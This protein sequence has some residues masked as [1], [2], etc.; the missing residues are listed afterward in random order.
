ML[1]EM[2]AVVRRFENCEY[3]P[4]D[5]H[6][7]DH[8][9]VITWYLERMPVRLALAHM[10]EKLAK[11]SAHHNRKGYNETITCFWIARVAEVLATSAA[12]LP[13]LETTNHVRERLGNKDLIFDY[14]SRECLLSEQAKTTWLDPDLQNL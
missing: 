2:E 12:D 6:H 14:Y 10:R 9:T 8:L 11:F 13:L 3:L 4:E 1:G 7:A 5:F